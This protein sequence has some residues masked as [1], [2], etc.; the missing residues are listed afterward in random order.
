M[1]VYKIGDFV[2]LHE[3]VQELGWA[4]SILM[5]IFDS[6]TNLGA[7]KNSGGYVAGREFS[8]RYPG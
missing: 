6:R 7:P 1:F 4:T 5:A 2:S 8:K 3:Q